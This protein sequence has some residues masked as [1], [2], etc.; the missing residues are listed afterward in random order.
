MFIDKIF[1]VFVI[2]FSAVIHEYAHGWMAYQLGDPTAKRAGR[3][4]INPI[5]HL[6]MFGSIILPLIMV[7]LPGGFLFAYAKPVPYNPYNLK[8]Q[9]WGPVWV[10]IAGP[11]SNIILALVFGVIAQILTVASPIYPFLQLIVFANVILAVF[12]MVPIPP[13]D[14]SKLL[15]ALLPDRAHQLKAALQQYG[16]MLLLL[17]IF[18][19]YALIFPI[20]QGLT[21]LF[22]AWL[23]P[24]IS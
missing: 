9:R 15:F 18:V 17:F 4:T 23:S 10:A 8:D 14:G 7:I 12:N 24:F 13:L 3:L 20:I 11:I 1:F 19:G 21:I 5:P 22:L 6:D 2:I 16:L